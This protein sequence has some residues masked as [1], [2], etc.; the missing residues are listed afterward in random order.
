MASYS[1]RGVAAAFRESPMTSTAER[2]HP[3]KNPD[4][5]FI[6]G[7]WVKPSGTSKLHVHDSATEDVF[8]SVAEAEVADVD[9]AVAAAKEAF[10]RGPWP[11]MSH[12]E[13]AMWMNKLAD[14]WE[15]R[16]DDLADTWTRESGVLR[17]ISGFASYMAATWRF[18][19]GLAETFQWEE[20]H[21]SQ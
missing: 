4:A 6:G 17:S 19:A 14:E 2:T 10:D 5:F 8:L 18:Y 9:R 1:G 7:D 12:A 16:G 15:K 11:R 13:R 21:I 3:I 20:K